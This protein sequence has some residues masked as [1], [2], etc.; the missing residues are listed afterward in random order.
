MESLA[1]LNTKTADSTNQGK[2]FRRQK[3]YSTQDSDSPQLS[4]EWVLLTKD[5]ELKEELGAGSF[6]SVL[7]ARHIKSNT[8]VA[9]KLL[10][11]QFLDTY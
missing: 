6:G 11:K 10:K 2:A 9:I 1:S 8:E 7:K 4:P 3:T 5:Y